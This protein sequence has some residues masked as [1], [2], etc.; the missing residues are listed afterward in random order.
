MTATGA[1]LLH[2][3]TTEEA[4]GT[5]AERARAATAGAAPTGAALAMLKVE[6]AGGGCYDFAGATVAKVEPMCYRCICVVV[7]VVH[8]HGRLVVVWVGVVCWLS[9]K[10]SLLQNKFT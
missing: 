9:T 8:L 4:G 5:R 3:G 7:I 6:T 2:G 10:M 1:V